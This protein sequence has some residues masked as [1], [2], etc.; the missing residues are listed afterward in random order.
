MTV[1]KI[2]LELTPAEATELSMV[3]YEYINMPNCPE[4]ES[5]KKC[6]RKIIRQLDTLVGEQERG[7]NDEAKNICHA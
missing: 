3:L 1:E 2:V 5:I 6:M 7:G 4:P